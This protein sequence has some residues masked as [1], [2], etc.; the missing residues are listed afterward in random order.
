[1]ADGSVSLVTHGWHTDIALP[2]AEATGRLAAFRAVFPGARTLVFGYGKRTFMIAPAHT[3][4]EWII[5]PF[6]GPAAIEVS[7]ISGDAAAAYGAAHVLTLP[8]PPGGAE[9]LSDFLWAAI[10]KTP[11]GAPAYIAVGNWPGSQFYDAAQDYGL[12]HTCN[13]WSAEALAA[14]GVPVSPAGVVFSGSLDSQL[15]ALLRRPAAS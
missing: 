14:G 15:R 11:A 10:A 6:P 1:M 2:A 9:G 3:I 13:R 5:G 8:L 7:A 12:T 4:G